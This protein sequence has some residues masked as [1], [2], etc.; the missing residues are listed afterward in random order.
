MSARRTLLTI[1]LGILAFEALGAVVAIAANWPAQFGA[2][3]TDAG[4]EALT[5]GTALSAP[6][7]PLVVLAGAV[8][9]VWRGRVRPGAAI[10][11]LVAVVMLVGALGEALAP[12]T[13]DVPKA[14][15]LASGAIGVV[16]AAAT[17]AAAAAAW[18]AQPRPGT[19]IPAS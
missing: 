14:V 16:L 9:L 6:L 15:L 3:G 17:A 13:P 1:G 10:M 7:A 8:A 11:A 5:R 18:R 2:V 4:A 19:A 12:A